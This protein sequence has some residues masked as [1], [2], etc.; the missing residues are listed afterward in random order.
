MDK[1]NDNDTVE[2]VNEP[3]DATANTEKEAAA[4]EP[5][6]IPALAPPQR[7]GRVL[8]MLAL[9]LALAA[10]AAAAWLY[11]QLQTQQSEYAEREARLG[12]QVADI[13]QTVQAARRSIGEAIDASQQTT[14]A[15]SERLADERNRVEAQLADAKSSVDA[16][17]AALLRQRQQLIELRSTDRVDWSLAET[18]YLLRLAFQRLLTAKDVGSALALLA[19]ADAILS[20]IDDTDLLPARSA[21]AQD[22]AALRA[23][24]DIDLEGTWLR[25]QA[26]AGRV[27]K[28]ILFELPEQAAEPTAVDPEAGWQTRL[29]QGIAAALEKIR[30][31][32]VIR[33]RDEPYAVLMDPQW[34]QLVRQNLRMQ[35]AQAQA[36]L[37]SGNAVLYDASLTSTRRWLGEFFDFNEAEVQALNSELDALQSVTITRDYPDIGGSLNALKAVIDTRHEVD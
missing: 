32:L 31:Y 28:L 26:L 4:P 25:L 15:V 30:G 5:P 14:M 6:V 2:S 9:L 16:V 12:R 10:V 34:E 21:I 37:L 29:R 3:A 24:P 18:E 35:L 1:D 27:D 13:D 17:Q 20:E 7:G 11:L 36:A 33:R 8:A 22:M 23:I 19:S